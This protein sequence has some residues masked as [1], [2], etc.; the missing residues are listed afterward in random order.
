M[1]VSKADIITGVIKYTKA[2]IVDKITDKPLKIIIA[3]C[4]AAI[5][6]NPTVADA[7]FNNEFVSMIL[8]EKDG[9]YDLDI[10]F[11]A[12]E[13]AVMEYGEFSITIPAIKFISPNEKELTF[14][15]SDVHTL[16]TYISGG[17]A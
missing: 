1:Y 7:I 4:I 11:S 6:I 15:M 2:E 5:E 10:M 13:K 17:N 8:S 14:T 16:K 3:T 9:R 12:L